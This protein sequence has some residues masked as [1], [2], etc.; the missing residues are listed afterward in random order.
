VFI[1][2]YRTSSLL[3]CR[4]HQVARPLS[5]SCVTSGELLWWL[6]RRLRQIARPSSGSMVV[7]VR[8]L[9]LPPV[10]GCLREVA[11]PSSGSIVVF[12]RLR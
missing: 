1:L 11:R 3:Q 7:L 5:S 10:H 8:S 2:F 9:D 12:V 4:L 6:H